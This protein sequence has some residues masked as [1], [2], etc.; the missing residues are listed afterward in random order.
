MARKQFVHRIVRPLYAARA[1]SRQKNHLANGGI[2]FDQLV[3]TDHL[4]DRKRPGDGD[5]QRTLGYS[6]QYVAYERCELTRFQ[7]IVCGNYRHHREGGA[8]QAIEV[9]KP[10]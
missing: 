1:P 9:D 10:H 3:G 7:E 4:T 8:R 6:I 5:F 2:A